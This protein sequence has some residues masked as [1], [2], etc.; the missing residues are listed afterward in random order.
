LSWVIVD[1]AAPSFVMSTKDLSSRGVAHRIH[2]R[3]FSRER[4]PANRVAR[5]LIKIGVD[6]R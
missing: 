4:R 1:I 6:V 2:E 5:L 3:C